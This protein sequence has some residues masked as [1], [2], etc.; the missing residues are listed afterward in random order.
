MKVNDLMDKE[1]INLAYE[2][3]KRLAKM[4][5][6]MNLAPRTHTKKASFGDYFKTTIPQ[7]LQEVEN[8]AEL[9]TIE[10]GLHKIFGW[11]VHCSRH[12]VERVFGRERDVPVSMIIRAFQ[13]LRDKYRIQLAKATQMGEVECVVGDYSNNL[14]IVFVL[15]GKSMELMTIMLKNPERF[16]LKTGTM[17]QLSF[18]V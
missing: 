9:K 12:F 18:R 10:T 1:Q 16:S 2:A 13:K 14:N 6:D 15:R 8:S 3:G 4:V 7:P 17:K 11:E 5:S